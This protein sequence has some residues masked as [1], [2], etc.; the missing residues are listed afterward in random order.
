MVDSP[1]SSSWRDRRKGRRYGPNRVTVKA[2]DL[3]HV[4]CTRPRRVNT[5][6]LLAVLALLVAPFP[7]STADA[8][9][10]N[11]T[12]LNMELPPEVLA[13][14]VGAGGAVVFYWC[15]P[16]GDLHRLPTSRVTAIGG[17]QGF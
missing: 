8:A 7:G 14:D 13:V 15:S 12:P 5:R 9:P 6:R 4:E 16:I 17:S 3:R 1:P 11:G 2:T 10:P